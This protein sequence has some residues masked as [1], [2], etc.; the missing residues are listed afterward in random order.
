MK[1]VLVG[2]NKKKNTFLTRSM[3]VVVGICLILILLSLFYFRNYFATFSLF[4]SSGLLIY[5]YTLP[6]KKINIKIS[7]ENIE[8]NDTSINW[9]KI[10]SWD[11]LEF[12]QWIEI[13]LFTNNLSQTY[14]T[15]YFKRENID[16]LNF[17]GN[18]M[19][20]YKV[21]YDKGMSTNNSFQN[22]LRIISLK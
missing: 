22:L 14:I 21:K 1:D 18:T 6:S 16:K 3:F 20:F 11:F 9:S 4:I 17:F 7:D 5:Y 2:Y 10:R 15:F 13:T 19:N 8:I 12:E